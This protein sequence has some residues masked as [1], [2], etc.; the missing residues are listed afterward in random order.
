MCGIKARKG[1]S[2]RPQMSSDSC[3][4]NLRHRN[5]IMGI[6]K[7]LGVYLVEFECLE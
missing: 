7:D 1:S 3:V 4:Q 2:T 5:F 6:A